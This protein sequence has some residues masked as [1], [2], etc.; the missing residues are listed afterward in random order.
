MKNK[1]A[2]EAAILVLYGLFKIEKEFFSLGCMYTVLASGNFDFVFCQEFGDKL[3]LFWV[4]Y[5]SQTRA[6]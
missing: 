6:R 5:I 1:T 3:T 4:S 2:L